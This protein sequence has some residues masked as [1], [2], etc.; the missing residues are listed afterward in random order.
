MLNLLLLL[1]VTGY[2]HSDIP[3]LSCLRKQRRLPSRQQKITNLSLLLI[4]HF[5]IFT[6]LA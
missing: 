2:F 1:C 5:C 4:V 6:L 3:I